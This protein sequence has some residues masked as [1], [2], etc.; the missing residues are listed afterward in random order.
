VAEAFQFTGNPFVDSGL[1]VM[2]H[3]AGLRNIADLTFAE[4]R[5][6]VGNGEALARDNSR[7]CQGFCV[8][9]S[10]QVIG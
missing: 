6:L 3:L 8:D 5:A 2:T 9:V 4:V 1:A 7:I 10:P